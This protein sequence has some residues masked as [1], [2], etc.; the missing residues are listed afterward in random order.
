[1][2]A[3]IPGGTIACSPA[4]DPSGAS[5]VSSTAWPFTIGVVTARPTSSCGLANAWLGT[6]PAGTRLTARSSAVSSRPT[7]TSWLATTTSVIRT[8]AASVPAGRMTLRATT[9][10]TVPSNTARISGI[11][12]LRFMCPVSVG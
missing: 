7:A 11:H 6:F 12:V 3:R 2:I 9:S 10:A 4:P 1:M 5:S 8:W